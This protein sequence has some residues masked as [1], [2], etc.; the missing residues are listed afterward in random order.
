MDVLEKVAR[1]QVQH[2]GSDEAET[3]LVGAGEGV[4]DGEDDG[5]QL[6]PAPGRCQH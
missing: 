6:R 2:A 4:G 3:L 1:L 5:V